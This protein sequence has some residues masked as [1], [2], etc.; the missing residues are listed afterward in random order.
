MDYPRQGLDASFT[1]DQRRTPRQ[2]SYSRIS[3]NPILAKYTHDYEAHQQNL[4]G[5]MSPL[6]FEF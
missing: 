4:L 5:E 6:D 1:S 2:F 3:S